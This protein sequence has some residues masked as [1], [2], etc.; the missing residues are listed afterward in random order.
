MYNNTFW[1][2][3]VV[4]VD[5]GEV[6]QEGTEQSAGH[7]NNMEAGISDASVAAALQ[8]IA[9]G[10]LQQQ[11]EIER[12]VVTLT[13]S[14]S[15]PFNNSAQTISLEITRNSTDYTVDVDVQEHAGNVGEIHIYDKQLN[16]FKVKYDGS[17]T[18]ATLILRVQ[19]GM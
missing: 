7:F 4:D 14:A 10:N 1:R 12:H 5:T 6:I 3:K 2:D 16:G 8:L 19:G 15:Y 11:T 17:A 13:N 18:S 9:I